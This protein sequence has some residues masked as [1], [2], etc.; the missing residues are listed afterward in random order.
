MI[1]N[2]GERKPEQSAMSKI[3]PNTFQTPNLYVDRLMPL[4]TDIEL[5]VL[6]YMTRR[7]LGF[8]RREDQI[9]LS[10]FTDGL[11]STKNGEQ[12]DHGAGISKE[13]ARTA[14]DSLIKLGIVTQTQPYDSAKRVPATWSLQLDDSLIDWQALQERREATKNAG[15]ERAAKRRVR[16]KSPTV[17]AGSTG[18]AVLSDS[19]GGVL[20]GS[21]PPS[22]PLGHPS[23]T[24]LD[25]PVL[26]GS[27]TITSRK[28]SLKPEE[29]QIYDPPPPLQDHK[30]G[31]GGFH[32][33]GLA[34][35]LN[36]QPPNSNGNNNGHHPPTDTSAVVRSPISLAM[37]MLAS[38]WAG[39]YASGWA[40]LESDLV[41]WDDDQVRALL[42]W[43]YVWLIEDAGSNRSISAYERADW[44]QHYERHYAS[45][46]AGATNRIGLIKSKVK[47]QI[48]APL[49][50]DDVAGLDAAIEER[51]FA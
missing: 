50:D 18:G 19:T 5:R 12:L 25:T 15:V 6:I 17:Q 29:S 51:S 22:Y 39:D 33:N 44:T 23:P 26:P 28:T 35:I 9:S 21:T 27:T 42:T 48:T 32:G 36:G 14:L 37:R 10:Q 8:N 24:G 20:P 49:T 4:L 2:E 45:V 34:K 7:I 31:G 3:I 1:G 30:V 40:S 16:E 38:E 41:G 47:L 43:L 13:A 11:I 46:Y